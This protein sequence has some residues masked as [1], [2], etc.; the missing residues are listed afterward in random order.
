MSES[1]PFTAD[2]PGQSRSPQEQPAGVEAELHQALALHKQGRLDDA[3]SLYRV[4]LA[5]APL[6]FDA[7]HLL[8]IVQY[9]KGRHEAAIALFDRAIIVGPNDPFGHFNRALAFDALKRPEEALLGWDRVLQIKPD[10]AEA[11]VNRGNALA[12]LKHFED[13]VLSYDRALRFKPGFTDALNSRGAALVELKRYNDAL[14]CWD[15]LLQLN[16]KSA[17]VHANRAVTLEMLKR[18]D[19]ALTS[20]ERAIALEPNSAQ[21]YSNRGTFLAVELKRYEQAISDYEQVLRLDSEYPYARGHLVHTRLH[22]CDW[23]D[24]EAEAKAVEEGVGER[25]RVCWPF[26]FQVISRSPADLKTCAEIFAADHP[27]GEPLWRGER[28]RH[29][30]VRL[31][32]VSGEFRTHAT[33]YLM[34]GLFESH[35][36]GRFEIHAFDSGIDDDSPVRKRLAAAFDSVTDISRQ[37]D[38]AAAKS[39]RQREIDVL[40]DLNGYVGRERIDVFAL[41]PSPLQVNYLGFPGTMGTPFTDYIVADRI[42]IPESEQVHYSEKVVYLPDTYQVND[43]RRRIAE[44]TPARTEMGLPE[45]GFVFATFNSSYKYTPS[46]FDIWMRLLRAVDGSVLWILETNDAAVR[47][48]KR[49]AQARGV[50]A[51]RL[52]FAPHIQLEEHLARQRLADLFLDT[53]PYNAHT[54]ASDAL[55]A[56]L[57]VLT[58]AGS[59]FAGRVAA[60]L[61]SAVG[62]PELV[63][64]NLADYEALALHLARDADALAAVKAKLH[65]NRLTMPLFDTDRFRRHLEAAFT[66][67]W[68]RHDRGQ[69]PESFAVPPVE[70]HR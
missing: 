22:C 11:H 25:R 29:D 70:P 32:Y 12:Q 52:I 40:I 35:D 59:A 21:I 65:A 27:P 2:E 57:P 17:D 67:M 1:G 9:Q 5:S 16:P 60:G 43:S 69:P 37:S 56:G 46:M 19:E 53:L 20:H 26:T 64:N 30:K 10:Y 41:R 49:E 38:S 18:Y 24:F 23:R 61:L 66:R 4:V 31:G 45:T 58:C 28:Y 63:T 62:L 55:W 6:N 34:A 51:E 7:L 44:R 33:S 15:R 8:G 36:K 3:E 47:N 48:L 14:A 42:V 13:A 50:A 68:E 54:T 39:I